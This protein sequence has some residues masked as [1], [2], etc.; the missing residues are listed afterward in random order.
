MAGRKFIDF[1]GILFLPFCSKLYMIFDLLFY[2]LV[3]IT[4]AFEAPNP[5]IRQ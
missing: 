4:L 3:L 2:I 5:N 1:V